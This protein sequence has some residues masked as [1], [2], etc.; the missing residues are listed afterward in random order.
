MYKS[1]APDNN[2]RRDI[3]GRPVPRTEVFM[4]ERV[5]NRK[6]YFPSDRHDAK[7]ERF[8][9]IKQFVSPV[10]VADLPQAAGLSEGSRFAYTLK[11]SLS[12]LSKAPNAG[13]LIAPREGSP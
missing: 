3:V 2:A 7:L 8:Q 13:I 10:L 1:L 5:Q 12:G 11:K 9:A 6:K 4:S